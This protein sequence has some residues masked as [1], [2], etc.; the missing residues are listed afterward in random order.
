[1]PSATN[2][3]IAGAAPALNLRQQM[4]YEYQIWE[5]ENCTTC[6][7]TETI[8]EEMC[9]GLLGPNP[10]H[11]ATFT[12]TSNND[13]MRKY[14]AIMGWEPYKPMLQPDGTPFPEDESE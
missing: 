4:P 6:A 14:H 2:T 3:R 12:A 5:D 10:K 11:V 7:R 8:R 13:A 1:M 9:N